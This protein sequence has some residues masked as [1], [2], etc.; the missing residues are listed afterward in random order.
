M[1]VKSE[2]LLHERWLIRMRKE[3]LEQ[4]HTEIQQHSE[5]SRHILEAKGVLIQVKLWALLS[6]VNEA[7]AGLD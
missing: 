6:Q 3:K 7:S 2:A 1:S 5:D 4:Q